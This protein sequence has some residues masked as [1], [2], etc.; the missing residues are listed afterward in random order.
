[1]N[2]W[3][4]NNI[5]QVKIMGKPLS[6][7]ENVNFDFPWDLLKIKKEL[8]DKFLEKKID[9]SVQIA[10]N[11]VIKGKVFIGNN[12][13]VKEGAV[14]NGPCYIGEN[15]IIGNNCVI[16]PYTNI[17][18]EALIGSN[19]EIKNSLLGEDVHLHSNYIGDSILGSGVRI[20]AG[21]ITANTRIDRKEIKKG[22]KKL[23][24]IIG[25]GVKTGIHC[26]LM[27]GI[28]IGRDSLIGPHSLVLNNLEK[29]TLFYNRFKTIKKKS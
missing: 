29:E 26:S 22:F 4:K 20:G 23:G 18:K 13:V 16:R 10:D 25:D 27:P 15:S 11:A 21:T 14:I 1:M 7:Y 9:S 5:S 24:A 2:D 19:C 17:E 6:F 3:L 8:F 28:L 12:I